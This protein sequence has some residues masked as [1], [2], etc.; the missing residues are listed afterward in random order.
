MPTFRRRLALAL[1]ALSAAASAAAMVRKCSGFSGCRCSQMR[2][3][4]AGVPPG[5]YPRVSEGSGTESTASGY[6]S[7]PDKLLP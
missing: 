7:L 6:R 1:V 3:H 5:T 4:F 2:A